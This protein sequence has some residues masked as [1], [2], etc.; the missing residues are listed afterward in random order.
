MWGLG[1][2]IRIPIRRGIAFFIGIRWKIEDV[3]W[4]F[5]ELR[6]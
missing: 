5:I 1:W 4:A 6:Y 2:S 3:R